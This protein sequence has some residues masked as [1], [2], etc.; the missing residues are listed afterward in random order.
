MGAALITAFGLVIVALI[1]VF[2]GALAQR[3]AAKNA[4]PDTPEGDLDVLR[5]M[6]ALVAQQEARIEE[7]EEQLTAERIRCAECEAR[8]QAREGAP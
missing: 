8:E 2:G 6:S 4:P 1:T 3:W 5:A 7:L